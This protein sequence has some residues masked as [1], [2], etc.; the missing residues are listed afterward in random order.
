MTGKK[1]SGNIEAKV[2]V[3]SE[4]TKVNPRH[5]AVAAV[6]DPKEISSLWGSNSAGLKPDKM[7]VSDKWTDQLALCRFFAKFDPIASGAISKIVEIGFND[8][9]IRK[10]L[11]SDEEFQVYLESRDDVI[12]SLQVAAR[13]YLTSGL[14]VPEITWEEV[15]GKE[16]GIKNKPNKKYLLPESIWLRDPGKIEL[17]VS[18]VPTKARVYIKI[19]SEDISFIKN[20][21]KYSD[22]TE[23]KDL[24]KQLAKDYP[25]FVKKVQSENVSS[26]P[27]KDAFIIR[28]NVSSGDTYPTPYLLSAMESLMHK[29]NLK[30]M[31]Y[32]IAARVTSAIQIIKLGNDAFPLTE[33]DQPVIDELRSQMLWRGLPNNQERV[34]QLFGNHT[35]DIS[36]VQ[37]DTQAL[38]NEGKYASVN[39]DILHALGLPNM[40][41][42]GESSRSGSGSAEFIMLPPTEMIKSIRDAFVPFLEYIV[43]SIKERNNFK[44]TPLINFPPPKLYDPTKLATIGEKYF[45][46]GVISKTTWAA[47]GGFNFQEETMLISDDNELIQEMGLQDRPN[48][49]YESPNSPNQPKNTPVDPKKTLPVDP[50]KTPPVDPKNKAVQPPKGNKTASYDQNSTN[51]DS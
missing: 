51:F 49:P 9:Y 28:R 16:I 1:I 32:S 3:S 24:Y 47:L 43:K 19:S 20:K 26:I 17:K 14:L 31:D 50:K 25:E 27:L 4:P 39:N 44:N 40:I 18:P 13:E 29:R 23:D 36:W 41:I 33:D 6:Y 10:G 8:L 30:K 11:C 38:L 5:I 45:Q 12:E 46:N 42:T 21:G 37:P 22:G 15:P 48:V 7:G 35:L 2:A 34:F